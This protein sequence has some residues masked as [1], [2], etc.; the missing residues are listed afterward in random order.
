MGGGALYSVQSEGLQLEVF[1]I[2]SRSFASSALM[3]SMSD[4]Q[5]GEKKGHEE[6]TLE[7]G[8]EK[9]LPLTL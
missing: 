2:S 9:W 1:L 6:R 7:N 8:K 4:L 5:S 3:A